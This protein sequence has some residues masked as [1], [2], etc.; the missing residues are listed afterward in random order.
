MSVVLT[1][2]AVAALALCFLVWLL[3]RLRD[4]SQSSSSSKSASAPE[5][6]AGAAGSSP[7]VVQ[8][9]LS[10]KELQAHA[11]KAPEV[12]KDV[13]FRVQGERGMGGPIWGDVMCADGVYLPHVW[14]SD[15]HTSYDG[16]W[17]RTG[18]Y[19]SDTAH[20]VDRKSRRSWWISKAEGEVLDAVHWR[21]PRWSGETLNESGIAD[22]AH[23]VMSDA[24]FEAWLAEHLD[25][26]PQPLVALR[27]IWVPVECVP[28]EASHQPPNLPVAPP[29]LR[30]DGKTQAPNV[31]APDLT[32]ERHW[33]ASLRSL[34]SPL[35][36][37]QQASWALQMNGKPTGWLLDQDPA[38]VWRDDGQGLA[39]Y[40]YPEQG[41]EGRSRCLAVWTAEKGWHAWQQQLPPDRKPWTIE[42][43]WPDAADVRASL[44]WSGA[45]LLQR[46]QVDT[47]E[48][49][50][51]HE[52]TSIRCVTGRTDACAGH[53]ADGRAKLSAQPV[54]TFCWLRDP[55]QPD[56]WRAQS[57]P[58]LGKPLI[59]TLSKEARDEPGE[60]SAW[61]LQWGD[62]HL[63][64][65]W[66]LEHVIVKGRWALLM[67]FARAP[68][69]GGAGQVQVWDGERLQS[70][71]LPWPVTRLRPVPALDG[72]MADRVGLIALTACLDDKDWDPATASWRWN[73][74]SVSSS[75]LS[76]PDWR[77]LYLRREIA[78]D[79]QGRWRLQ[80]RW[81]E[82]QQIQHPRADGDY[83]WRDAVRGDALW[84]WG[85]QNERLSSS[86]SEDEC[87]IEGVSMTRSGL[88]LCGTG[89]GACPHPAGEGWVVME[90]VERRYGQ[91]NRWKLHWL[92]SV[93]KELRTLE[94]AVNSPQLKGWDTQGLHWQELAPE[95][96]ETHAAAPQLVT[97][98][99][100]SRAEVEALR[101]GTSGL[102]LRKQ[103][104]RY[105]EILLGQDD[106]PWRA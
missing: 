28:A 9:L 86:W 49:E 70:V 69:R 41:E 21:V 71:D 50:R 91:P 48:T 103:D 22:D 94:L 27:D 90:F 59:W 75:H 85:G 31:A 30:D 100:W 19:D 60:T 36:P 33:P 89:P 104:L 37:L 66:A 68:E 57:E 102:W 1:L 88:A 101:Q 80:P 55:A 63:S 72:R 99:M 32:L 2:I 15:L 20:L 3:S 11:D 4:D 79:A 24:S 65:S 83:V 39:L 45:L 76:R 74:H 51:L 96:G 10:S 29:V 12:N 23:V 62:K 5:K 98:A 61:N 58:V 93:E 44:Q 95:E 78:P 67:P 26:K 81:R 18:F 35:L 64:G 106:C 46:V 82:V 43:F 56:V 92:N 54:T 52:G 7:P 14:E 42:P 47:P 34:H 105:A 13:S 87:R 8:E 84:W 53:S 6:P 17:L 25:A 73:A 40:A 16:R 97:L 38:M 77:A